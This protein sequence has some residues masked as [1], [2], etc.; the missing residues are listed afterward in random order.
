MRK[1]LLFTAFMFVCLIGFQ[2]L[3]AQPNTRYFFV[4]LNTNPDKPEISE[5]E[6]ENLQTL[7]LANL[8]NLH[9]DGILNAAGPFDGGGGM[10]IVSAKSIEEA[11]E[12]VSTDPAVAADRYNVEVFPFQVVGNNVCGAKEP[13]E[14]VTYQFVRLSSNVEFFGDI[15]EM[16]YDDRFFMAE[17]N[18]END[19][20]M[21]YGR[22]SD[23]ND[24]IIIFDVPESKD[25]E[26][27]IKQHPAVKAGQLKYDI[28]PLWIAK[29]TFCKK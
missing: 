18:T 14:M 8:D 16:V 1:T 23:F 9:A 27:I 24:G 5:E 22:F 26:R 29:G 7:H 2:T 12:I 21:I 6:K 11:K 17:L 3:S 28:K 20:V 13:H 15:Q 10:L 19:Y 4:F 25:A